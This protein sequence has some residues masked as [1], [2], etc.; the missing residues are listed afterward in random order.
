MTH[1]HVQTG[2]LLILWNCLASCLSV[3]ATSGPVC[4]KWRSSEQKSVCTCNP[5]D[6]MAGPRR[7]RRQQRLLPELAGLERDKLPVCRSKYQRLPLECWQ[8]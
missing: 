1:K 5:P 4:T 6:G 7:A 2:Y 3:V 8:R